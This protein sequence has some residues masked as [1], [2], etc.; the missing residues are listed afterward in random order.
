M[1]DKTL[2]LI[3]IQDEQGFI[4]DA[5]I[6][7][8]KTSWTN[9]TLEFSSQIFGK[10]SFIEK[11][12]FECLT[13]LRINLAKYGCKPL[14]A[15]ARFD[16]YP[17]GMCRDM[18]N[19]LVA[20]VI[21]SNYLNEIQH[22]GIFD[23]AEPDLIATVEEQLQYFTSQISPSYK[24]MVKHHSGSIIEGFIHEN[25]IL[26]PNNIKFTSS[27]IPDINVSGNNHF[28]C[29]TNLR[30]ELEKYGY[31]PICNGARLD[32]YILPT[33]LDDDGLWL[34]ILQPGKLPSDF[35][36]SS[37]DLVETFGDADP[38]LVTSIVEQRKKYESW[39]DSIKHIPVSEYEKYDLLNLPELYF[40]LAKIG[41]LPSMWLFDIDSSI[42]HYADQFK[43]SNGRERLRA[44]SPLSP[45]QV[46]QIGVLKGEA[47]LGFIAGEILSLEYFTPNK[48]F[49]DF[50]HGVITSEAPKD[51]AI[52]DAAIKQQ[53]GWLY[54]IDN[55]V[56][57][58]GQEDTLPED[59]LGAFEIKNGLII[60]NSYQ[61]NEKYL[62]FGNKGL[63][64][65]PASLYEVL[66]KAL[67]NLT[68]E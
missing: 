47:I 58:S 60:A 53:E 25:R 16:V 68:N 34:H 1:N 32:T 54:I 49:K 7:Y 41:E 30:V 66:I 8:S 36:S 18:G 55:R 27:S 11:D 33:D 59:I 22:V 3:K 46:D 17:S 2:K 61:P 29:L 10:L 19:G 52:R 31:F 63:V 13:Q 44:L 12:V 37:E 6:E 38:D 5:Q 28:E 26:E 15:G 23:Y 50:I 39:L 67:E 42:Y 48:I 4:S 40:R 65:L 64:Q 51:S 57:N 43:N 20:Q 9:W 62:L 14:C 35:I 56:A 24:F 21:S 45:E